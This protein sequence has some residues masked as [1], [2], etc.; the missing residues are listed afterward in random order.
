MQIYFR[1]KA[2]GKRRPVLELI[3]ASLPD[4]VQ[5][6]GDAIRAI[7]TDQ[8]QRFNAR[9]TGQSIFPYLSPGQLEE[10][11]EAGKVGFEAAYDD[12]RVN[13]AAAA[14]TAF[15]AFEDGIYKVLINDTIVEDLQ[16]QLTIAPGSVFTFIRLTMLTG[17]MR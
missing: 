4:D 14:E 15:Q 9:S 6:L 5:C 1:V 12:R 10:Q 3:E 13:V 7:V 16:A 11:A 17:T 2:A 8:V